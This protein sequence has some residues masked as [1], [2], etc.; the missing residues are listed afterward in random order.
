[1]ISQNIMD[2]EVN[3]LM[4]KGKKSWTSAED[5]AIIYLVQ[6]HGAANWALIASGL[7]ENERTG[8]QCRERYHNHL[9]ANIK[10]GDWTKEEDM[11]IVELQAKYGNQ[12]AKI[13]K[14][15]PGRTDNAIKN[16]WHAAIRSQARQNTECTATTSP[17]STLNL[18]PSVPTLPLAN[19]TVMN[20]FKYSPRYEADMLLAE[21]MDLNYL[22]P[23]HESHSP[24]VYV[25]DFVD[26]LIDSNDWLQDFV[27]NAFS[28]E[29]QQPTLFHSES[30]TAWMDILDCV[31]GSDT[32][33]DSDSLNATIFS[34]AS[35]S[36][37]SS[38]SSVSSLDSEDELC[39]MKF[40]PWETDAY[41]CTDEEDIS[42]DGITTGA[43]CDD[44]ECLTG[45]E[46]FSL[47]KVSTPKRNFED[48][49]ATN[50]ENTIWTMSM[51]DELM[52]D[53]GMDDDSFV[54]SESS[55]RS[56]K[57]TDNSLSSF[58]FTY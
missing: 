38:S 21:T 24:E 48:A 15:L 26:N 36:S 9:Q 53:L 31:D 29:L 10:K 32:D 54:P 56:R 2:I 37:T 34:N 18:R 23:C 16:R 20:K 35:T 6:K 8:K 11:K 43:G 52:G 41:C 28:N 57:N 49:D 25:E 30:C 12:W 5:Q 39:M 45:M 40:N 19:A 3:E 42:M 44:D 46:D 7:K 17:K 47:F 22:S 51:D 14:E 13:T 4:M 58:S 27:N 1:M 50:T 33:S 55:K